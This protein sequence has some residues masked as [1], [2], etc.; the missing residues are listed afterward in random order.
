MA[1]PTTGKSL[2]LPIMIATF[3]I[4]PP[5]CSKKG[6]LPSQNCPELSY[7]AN[8][9]AKIRTAYSACRKRAYGAEKRRFEPNFFPVE[10]HGSIIHYSKSNVKKK[11]GVFA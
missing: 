10:L 5:F 7:F 1:L 2:S 6:S 3:F 8:P 4:S 11:Q 9:A